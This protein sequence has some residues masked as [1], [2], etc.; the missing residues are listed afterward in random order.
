MTGKFHLRKFHLGKFHRENSI[1]GKITL[2]KIPP[3]DINLWT[4][5]PMDNSNHGQFHLLKILPKRAL[6]TETTYKGFAE[7]AMVANLK[8]IQPGKFHQWKIQPTSNYTYGQ[9]HLW[10]FPPMDNS[11]HG[12]FHLWKIPLIRV[13]TTETT[14]KGIA[15]YPVDANLFRL[16]SSILKHA[17]SRGAAPMGI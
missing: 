9:F 3:V 5:Q 7:Y 10:T 2:L 8:K 14:D 4:F 1:C 17:G 12:Q 15:K 13:P 16:E 11:T 6:T